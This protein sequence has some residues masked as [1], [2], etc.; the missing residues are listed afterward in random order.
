ME[1]GRDENADPIDG[2]EIDEDVVVI[3]V[4]SDRNVDKEVDEMVD[5]ADMGRKKSSSSTS[6][7]SPPVPLISSRPPKRPAKMPFFLVL[8]SSRPNLR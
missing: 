2:E 6:L 7:R 5:E 4:A 3:V 8:S 1:S